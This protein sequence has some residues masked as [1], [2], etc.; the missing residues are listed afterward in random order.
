MSS[1]AVPVRLARAIKL[2][3]FISHRD[4]PLDRFVSDVP[5]PSAALVSAPDLTLDDTL[6]GLQLISDSGVTFQWGDQH[7]LDH[8]RFGIGLHTS[9]RLW[10][11][12]TPFEIGVA[13]D[14]ARDV[15]LEYTIAQWPLF[16]LGDWWALP[17]KYHLSGEE[18]LP[19][20][21]LITRSF[22]ERGRAIELSKTISSIT[23]AYRACITPFLA[24]VVCTDS[25]S[26][27][28]PGAKSGKRVRVW[29][30]DRSSDSDGDRSSDS[31]SDSEEHVSTN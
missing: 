2:S 10:S 6:V 16:L 28:V 12:L 21:S 14:W 7:T 22:S 31:D 29:C 20:S 23:P 15:V 13:M 27:S 26:V 5:Q 30:G 19:E 4:P 17:S 24:A 8:I 3:S 25:S 1:I 11:E 9:F 18:M